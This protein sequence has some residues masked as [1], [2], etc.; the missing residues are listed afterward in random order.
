MSATAIARATAPPTPGSLRRASTAS[1]SWSYIASTIACGSCPSCNYKHAGLN[2]TLRFS[3]TRPLDF[4]PVACSR[5]GETIL[6][7]GTKLPSY[8]DQSL[9]QSMV[10]LA[11]SAQIFGAVGTPT[12]NLPEMA[13]KISNISQDHRPAL[14]NGIEARDFAAP[15]PQPYH[16]TLQKQ[17]GSRPSSRVIRKNMKRAFDNLPKRIKYLFD[18][19]IIISNPVAAAA[20]QLQQPLPQYSKVAKVQVPASLKTTPDRLST[21]GEEPVVA[22]NMVPLSLLPNRRYSEAPIMAQ[23]KAY[24]RNCNFPSEHHRCDCTGNCH[25]SK[26]GHRPSI[27]SDGSDPFYVRP[28][29]SQG[30]GT[31]SSRSED[32]ETERALSKHS[33]D[34][35]GMGGSFGG[36]ADSSGH[37]R[38]PSLH[39]RNS[40]LS[41]STEISIGD[42]S[43]PM[44]P[45]LLS[46][47][48]GHLVRPHLRGLISSDAIPPQAI[49]HQT[50]ARHEENNGE[51]LRKG[52]HLPSGFHGA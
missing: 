28:Q 27:R 17:P 3:R 47:E 42:P 16:A 49:E 26:L 5:C 52:G 19:Q 45:P 50:A 21:T 41:G 8:A 32:Q 40:S 24:A 12:L 29:S 39:G 44:T 37:M 6:G 9:A 35:N 36:R 1:S 34:L 20:E 25:C 11:S 18:R 30:T 33:E 10:V 38:V 31:I 43:E 46:P 14:A 48:H 13:R 15:V 4:N 51:L 23:R 22:E 7:I 2:I